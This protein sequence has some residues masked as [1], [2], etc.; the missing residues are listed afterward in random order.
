MVMCEL[1]LSELETNLSNC[2][3]DTSAPITMAEREL[4]AWVHSVTDLLDSDQIE[5]LSEIWLDELACR[6]C[7]P[8]PTSSEWHLVSLAASARLAARLIGIKPA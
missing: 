3:P 7:L 6:E 2:L 8:E 5:S 4:A 1:T